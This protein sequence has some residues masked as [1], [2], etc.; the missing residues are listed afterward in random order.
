MLKMVVLPA[1]FGPMRPL[2]SPSGTSNEAA[3]TAR[4]PRKDLEIA[5]ASSSAIGPLSAKELN[6][7]DDGEDPKERRDE[8]QVDANVAFAAAQHTR[9][10]QRFVD[11][12]AEP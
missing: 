8:Q 4:R 11:R 3:F 9:L 2:M 10:H 7:C 1:P 5:R 12:V 6:D